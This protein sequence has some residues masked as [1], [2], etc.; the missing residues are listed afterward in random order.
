MRSGIGITFCNHK[1]AGAIHQQ[2]GWGAHI[3]CWRFIFS[4]FDIF[5]LS[6]RFNPGTNGGNVE[7]GLINKGYLL[8]L[9][10]RL[11]PWVTLGSQTDKKRM[12]WPSGHTVCRRE[13]HDQIPI[14]VLIEQRFPKPKVGGSTPLGTANFLAFLHRTKFLALFWLSCRWIATRNCAL[15]RAARFSVFNARSC[16]LMSY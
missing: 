16:T 7:M 14:M 3:Y 4:R 9:N 8:T 10:Q 5:R 6:F 11:G 15:P 1:N 12:R 2:R 13:S